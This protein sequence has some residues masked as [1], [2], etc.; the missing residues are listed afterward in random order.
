MQGR[1]VSAPLL[2]YLLGRPG[3]SL[4]LIT[5]SEVVLTAL[6]KPPDFEKE[7]I[8]FQVLFFFFFGS[9]FFFS[10]LLFLSTA[11]LL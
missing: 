9:C 7:G 4:A 1:R 6:N 8:F 2:G 5:L 3:V 11:W 10:S